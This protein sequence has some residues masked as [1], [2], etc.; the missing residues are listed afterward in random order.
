MAEVGCCQRPKISHGFLK[1]AKQEGKKTT[2]GLDQ[3]LSKDIPVL[4]CEPSCASALNDDMPDL[5]EDEALAAKLKSGVFIIDQFLYK[6]TESGRLKVKFISN[7]SEVMV[8]G[9]CHQ[10]A[11]YGTK[12]MNSILNKVERLKS[13][14][15]N[16]GC[17]G[18]AGS[19]GYEKEHYDI[20]EKIGAE[21]LFPAVDKLD[22]AASVVASG[23]SCRHQIEHHTNKKPKHWVEVIKVE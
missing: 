2:L 22:E 15:V 6:E 12:S 14:E 13:S 3:Y 18:M 10:K 16:S 21:I 4:V 7:E 11:L 19:F 5:I 8:H 1:E 23:F 17:C 20:S 9:H